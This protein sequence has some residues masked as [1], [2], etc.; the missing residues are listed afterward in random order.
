MIRGA[1]GPAGTPLGA[2]G[3][4]YVQVSV[5]PT[6]SPGVW[7]MI[8]SHKRAG[9]PWPSVLRTKRQT[10]PGSH[11]DLQSALIAAALMLAEQA[12]LRVTE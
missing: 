2:R 9:R 3:V 5:Y 12:G 4:E 1:E 8:Y 7:S 10:L 6:G 11:Q